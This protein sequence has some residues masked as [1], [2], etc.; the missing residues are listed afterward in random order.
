MADPVHPPAGADDPERAEPEPAPGP[1]ASFSALYF[2]EMFVNAGLLLLVVALGFAGIL[3]G[4]ALDEVEGPAVGGLV[5]TAAGVVVA[6]R[7]FRRRH[8]ARQR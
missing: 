6:V 3:L 1:A 8:R 7:L 4:L 2:R 5:G